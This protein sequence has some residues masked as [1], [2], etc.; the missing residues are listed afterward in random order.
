MTSTGC[1]PS[2]PAAATESGES[3]AIHARLHSDPTIAS[4][5]AATLLP[6]LHAER[7]EL[8]EIGST[9]DRLAR[10]LRIVAGE[11]GILRHLLGMGRMGA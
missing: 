2:D 7:Q 9:S 3:A 10:L 6:L 1:G 8:L 4:Y 11:T 5:Q